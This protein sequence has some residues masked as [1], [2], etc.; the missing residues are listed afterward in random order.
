MGVKTLRQE[1]VILRVDH[2][3]MDQRVKHLEYTSH[4]GNEEG[5]SLQNSSDEEIDNTVN[6][7]ADMKPEPSN[8]SFL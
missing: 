4:Q 5:T 7:T 8:G 6:P 2:G 1:L 3:L